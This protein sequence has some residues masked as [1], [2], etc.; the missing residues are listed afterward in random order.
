MENIFQA[1]FV[2]YTLIIFGEI[3][4]IPSK[5]SSN[6]GKKQVQVENRGKK[7]IVLQNKVLFLFCLVVW[8]CRRDKI[9]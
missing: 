6:L 8:E 5:N 9:T 7:N 4:Y 2:N 1:S 3:K